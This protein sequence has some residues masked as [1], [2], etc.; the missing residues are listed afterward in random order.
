MMLGVLGDAGLRVGEIRLRGQPS[1]ERQRHGSLD[2]RLIPRNSTAHA[3]SGVGAPEIPDDGQPGDIRGDRILAGQHYPRVL[4]DSA[5]AR[6]TGNHAARGVDDD[7]VLLSGQVSFG[8]LV[9]ELSVEVTATR[10]RDAAEPGLQRQ[11]EVGGCHAF[12]SSG[13]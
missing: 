1:R 12:C 2:L 9:G 13:R 4:H 5:G 11:A 3:G 10:P 7:E 6:A 8:R